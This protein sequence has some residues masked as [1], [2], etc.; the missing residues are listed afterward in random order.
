MKSFVKSSGSV[1]I[2]LRNSHD[3][4]THKLYEDSTLSILLIIFPV[5][6]TLPGYAMA[7]SEWLYF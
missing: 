6:K 5:P 1:S 2:G 7:T 3:S 4:L